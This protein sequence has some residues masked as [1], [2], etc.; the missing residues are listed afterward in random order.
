MTLAGRRGALNVARRTPDPL[1]GFPP[2]DDVP[3]SPKHGAERP[4]PAQPSPLH[5]AQA[6]ART[7]P[8]PPR[9]PKCSRTSSDGELSWDFVAL[10]GPLVAPSGSAGRN[11]TFAA[12]SERR[13]TPPE[14]GFLAKR[15]KGLEP[16]TFC[17]ASRRSSQL[18]YSRE[19]P[20]YIREHRGRRLSV[21]GQLR[22]LATEGDRVAAIVGFV[23]LLGVA[24]A[25]P[26]RGCDRPGR[27]AVAHGLDGP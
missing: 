21:G 5:D 16:S 25:L 12:A 20:E 27:P 26:D 24:A 1:T 15:L 17:M 2:P 14:R 11:H 4:A 10:S 18:S 3:V 9:W 19:A 22:D 23:E 13:K 7:A 6:E 8:R